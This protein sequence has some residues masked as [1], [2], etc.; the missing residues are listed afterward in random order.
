LVPEVFVEINSE[1]AYL[2][3][4][5]NGQDVFIDTPR[6][7]NVGPFKAVVGTQSNDERVK[8]G[9]VAIPW[10]WGNKGIS[11]GASANELTI[12]ALEMNIKMPEYKTCLCRIHK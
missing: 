9:V 5:D 1:D 4:I 8:K 7:S 11:T 3:G 10:H 2:A 6:A 12:D